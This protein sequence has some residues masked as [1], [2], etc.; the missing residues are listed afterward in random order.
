MLFTLLLLALP[1]SA[2]ERDLRNAC[3]H[4]EVMAQDIWN[5]G[6]NAVA[7]PVAQACAKA[8]SDSWKT[9]S[10]V[11]AGVIQK[12]DREAIAQGRNLRAPAFSNDAD[13]LQ[14]DDRRT[15]AFA[16]VPHRHAASSECFHVCAQSSWINGR[17]SRPAPA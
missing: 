5:C 10:A 11:L 17:S 6:D 1:A 14:E 13:A 4:Y 9:E 7:I 3:P 8:I 12:T 16:D 2:A 15:A